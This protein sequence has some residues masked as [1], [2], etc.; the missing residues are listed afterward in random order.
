MEEAPVLRPLERFIDS[1][2]VKVE[3]KPKPEASPPSEKEPVQEVAPPKSEKPKPAP[4][5]QPEDIT[6]LGDAEKVAQAGFDTVSRAGDYLTQE[7]LPNAMGYRLR[8]I[9]S[10]SMLEAPPPSTDGQTI[11]PPPD[12]TVRNMFDDMFEKGSWQTLVESGE[13]MLSEFMF[14][15]DLH[16]FVAEGLSNLGEPYQDAHDAVCRKTSF[17]IHRLSGIENLSF[18]DGTP[19]A[20]ADTQQWLKSIAIGG[21]AAMAGSVVSGGS[22]DCDHMAETIRKA[23]AMAKKKKLA[24]AVSSLQQ[25]MRTSSSK[26]E[27][28]MWR[29][30]LSQILVNAKK[31]QLALPHLESVLQDIETYGLEEWDPDL[32]LQGFKMVWVGFSTRSDENGKAQT[33]DVLNRIARLDPA[34]ALRLGK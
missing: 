26:R 28:L 15:L 12:Q 29:L 4:P 10:W 25:E 27:Q 13:Q 32:A 14:W 1:I 6:S 30:G 23:Q 9:A 20:D 16:R 17:F 22:R 11:I 3:E 19:F 21:G 31:P 8:R 2:P 7:Q 24:E 33:T 5:T 18:S 34:E